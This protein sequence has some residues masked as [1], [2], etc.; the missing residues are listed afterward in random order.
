M[1]LPKYIPYLLAGIFIVSLASLYFLIT[2]K[3]DT[4]N[5]SDV[6]SAQSGLLIALAKKLGADNPPSTSSAKESV[7]PALK[8]Q[9]EED[10]II[11]ISDKICFNKPLD[12]DEKE[13]Q[14]RF[15]NEIKKESQRSKQTLTSVIDKFLAGK[16]DFNQSEQDFYQDNQADIDTMV[17]DKKLFASVIDKLVA[18]KTDF[19]P[20]E[21]EYQ[22]NNPKGIEAELARIKK[23]SEKLASATPPHAANDR[24]KIILSFFENKIPKTVSEICKLYAEKTNTNPDKGNFSRILGKIVDDGFLVCQSA[25]NG[26]KV[27]HG[28]PDWFENKKLKPEYQQKIKA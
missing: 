11:I 25:K 19:T 27:Y 1:Q 3:K 8:T 7:A 13:F 14:N 28:L 17:Q 16:N 24:L 5:Q 26:A 15:P 12:A 9:E 4:D 2:N 10:K 22:Q 6:L 18:G 23:G 21:L 20:A